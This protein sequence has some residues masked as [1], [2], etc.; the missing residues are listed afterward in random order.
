MWPKCR[1]I[2]QKRVMPP[3]AR[4]PPA[5][6]GRCLDGISAGDDLVDQAKILGFVR[7]HEM[8]AVERLLDLVIALAGVLDI[9]LVQAALQLDDVLRMTFDVRSLSLEAPR[10][11]VDHDAGV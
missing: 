11:L 2:R 9:D 5:S 3:F 6:G 10:R 1:K 7:G 4:R 8:V